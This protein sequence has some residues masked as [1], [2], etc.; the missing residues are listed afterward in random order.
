MPIALGFPIHAKSERDWTYLPPP[1]RVPTYCQSLLL[2]SSAA[3]SFCNPCHV[4]HAQKRKSEK[5]RGR[6]KTCHALHSK[7][8]RTIR[9][10]GNAPKQSK[11]QRKRRVLLLGAPGTETARPRT[12]SEACSALGR[13]S[14]QRQA[15]TR[16]VVRC[17]GQSAVGQQDPVIA[18]ANRE[19]SKPNPGTRRSCLGPLPSAPLFFFPSSFA[20][21]PR[22]IAGKVVLVSSPRFSTRVCFSLL[23]HRVVGADRLRSGTRCMGARQ[24]VCLSICVC[25]CVLVLCLAGI[26]LARLVAFL[27]FFETEPFIVTMVC[28]FGLLFNVPTCARDGP[29]P[30]QTSK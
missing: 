24:F 1:P 2:V 26:R 27:L 4:A 12:R 15:R 9:L 18:R 3:R 14:G 17:P 8:G 11:E 13:A 10:I 5:E 23:T 30:I 28:R 22:S 29:L 19:G 20:P 25:S 21:L 6:K 7:L 16:R